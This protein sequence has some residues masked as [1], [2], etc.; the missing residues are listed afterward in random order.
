[1][2]SS[3]R[4]SLHSAPFNYSVFKQIPLLISVPLSASPWSAQ[5]WRRSGAEKVLEGHMMC[6]GEKEKCT[7]RALSWA[8]NPRK[9]L[10]TYNEPQQSFESAFKWHCSHLFGLYPESVTLKYTKNFVIFFLP[11]KTAFMVYC[12]LLNKQVHFRIKLLEGHKSIGR[13]SCKFESSVCIYLD[14]S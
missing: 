6:L 13:S 11:F 7:K 9:K 10:I 5:C 3:L 4:G 1:M 12:V 14:C 2:P 8:L